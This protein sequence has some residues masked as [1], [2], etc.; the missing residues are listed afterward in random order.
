MRTRTH[1][2]TQA[3]MHILFYRVAPHLS[4]VYSLA[5]AACSQ[6]VHAAP[7]GRHA[8]AVGQTRGTAGSEAL[9]RPI[10]LIRWPRGATR[11]LVLPPN[12]SVRQKKQE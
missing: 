2:T 5:G 4:P 11:W 12:N 10:G 8:A 3:H 1:Q 6:C 9:Q 7:R